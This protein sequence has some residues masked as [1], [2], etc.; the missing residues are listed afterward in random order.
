MEREHG[1]KRKA[2][3]DVITNS[4]E[5]DVKKVKSTRV[6][7]VDPP[8]DDARFKTPQ[9]NLDEMLAKAKEVPKFAFDVNRAQEIAA[10]HAYDQ[11]KTKLLDAI[12]AG[13]VIDITPESGSPTPSSLS[14]ISDPK[15][16]WILEIK[17]ASAA[18]SFCESPLWDGDVDWTIANALNSVDYG[19]T[20]VRR[21]ASDKLSDLM[22]SY[23]DMKSIRFYFPHIYFSVSHV[24]GPL[25]ARTFEKLLEETKYLL[26]NPKAGMEGTQFGV[27]NLMN[28]E[29]DISLTA[30]NYCGEYP[31][32][33]TENLK[34]KLIELADAA[35]RLAGQLPDEI[36]QMPRL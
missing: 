31:M 9:Q 34:L 24:T 7:S 5:D 35:K 16:R 30:A 1:A 32:I 2:L 13:E 21:Y 27:V 11:F 8:Q 17:T 12:E 4:D 25:R 29:K 18:K 22:P 6:P 33:S 14:S 28:Q 3:L 19:R 26:S 20:K 23:E 10:N 36:P 15:R